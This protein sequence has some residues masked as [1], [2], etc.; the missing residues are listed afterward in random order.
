[1]QLSL[2]SPYEDVPLKILVTLPAA[3]PST[4]PPQLQLLSRY[5]G[6]FGAD[7]TLFG[8]VL[9]TYIS[10]NGVE[11]S[12]DTVCVF[13]GLQNV[14]D[15]C[16]QWYEERLN[17]EAVGSLLRHDGTEAASPL[18]SVDVPLST[19][20]SPAPYAEIPKGMQLFEAEPIVDR[21]SSFVGRACA[22]S[23]PAQVQGSIQSSSLYI[24]LELYR[25]R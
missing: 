24:L 4:S 23:D 5:V 14:L 10:V 1:M 16:L 6:A 15:R 19:G 12:P 22:I 2:P 25:C 13:D 9:R 18:P 21:K 8:S 20:G 7:S 17:K 11:W 3:Y